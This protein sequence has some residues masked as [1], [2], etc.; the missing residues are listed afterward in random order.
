MNNQ[1]FRGDDNLLIFLKNSLEEGL[2]SEEEAR[3]MVYTFVADYIETYRNYL[4]DYL[5]GLFSSFYI[6]FKRETGSR[7]K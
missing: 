4:G 7:A 3:K 2:P 5:K 1:I 6:F